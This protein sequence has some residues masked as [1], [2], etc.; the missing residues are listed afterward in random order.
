MIR[1]FR[2]IY[3]ELTGSI[4]L[5]AFILFTV[6]GVTWLSSIFDITR[7]LQFVQ[8]G[9]VRNFSTI[10]FSIFVEGLPFILL[11]ILVSSFIHVYVKEDMV[12]RILPRNPF[13]AIPMVACLGL[14]LPICECGI[15]PVA[16]RLIQKGFPAYIAFTFLLATP[17]INPVTI[18]STY[19]A[20]GDQWQ[21]VYTRVLF[22]AGIA[23]LMGILFFFVYGKKPADAIL[24]TDGS[25]TNHDCC[26]HDHDH[27]HHSHE[28]KQKD[29]HEH[30]KHEQ[31]DK[32]IHALHHGV[33]EFI[34][35]GKYFVLGAII[36]ALFQT[37]I[38]VSGI[39]HLST[40]D[41]LTMLLVMGVA[42]GIS[43][44]SSADAFI[45]AS[46]RNFL[47]T[48]SIVAFLVFGPMVDLKNISMMLGSFRPRVVALFFFGTTLITFSSILAIM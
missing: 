17:V 24:K 2:S 19:L 33:F 47:P 5:L 31:D 27:S 29:A 14:F 38:G 28:H 48:S 45:A 16:K 22:A 12:W 37:F 42:F 3:I 36:A 34:S 46:F 23:I 15:V 10:F 30:H 40:A 13:L 8:G 21:M 26:D 11:G 25:K 18:F 7:G 1:F 44:C 41:W 39:S 4:V 9:N 43:V 20:F 32:V 6:N 35:T